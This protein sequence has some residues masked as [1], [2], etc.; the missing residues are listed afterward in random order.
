MAKKLSK[1]EIT[2]NRIKRDFNRVFTNLINLGWTPPS[3][4]RFY[5]RLNKKGQLIKL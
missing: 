4:F 2:A 5:S 1:H 3:G